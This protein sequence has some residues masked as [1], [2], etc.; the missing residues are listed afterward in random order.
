MWLSWCCFDGSYTQQ[1][2][3][4]A[5]IVACSVE[6]GAVESPGEAGTEVGNWLSGESGPLTEMRRRE[7]KRDQ[8]ETGKLEMWRGPTLA[9]SAWLERGTSE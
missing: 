8:R 2:R 7:R 5:Y 6:A 3:D 4:D 9:L 1:G